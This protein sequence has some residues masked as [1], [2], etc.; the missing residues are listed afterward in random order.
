MLL[1]PFFKFSHNRNPKNEF[2]WKIF[3][4]KE[5]DTWKD[6]KRWQEF[7]ALGPIKKFEVEVDLFCDFPILA[8]R[9]LLRPRAF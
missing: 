3:S 8:K 1:S 7:I 2:F 5:L 4:K 6:K 9:G